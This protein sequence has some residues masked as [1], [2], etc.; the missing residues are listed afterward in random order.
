MSR[1]D[2]GWSWLDSASPPSVDEAGMET[3]RRAV[4]VFSSAD[5]AALLEHLREITVER[6]LGPEAGPDTLRDME[7]RRRLVL[8][9]MA[10]IRRGRAES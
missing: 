5:G 2:A 10:L 8:Y 6:C 9:L 7:G 4:R 1:P 3:A